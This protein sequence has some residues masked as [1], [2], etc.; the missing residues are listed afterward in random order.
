MFGLFGLGAFAPVEQPE[1]EVLH[2]KPARDR[3]RKAP[4]LVFIHG[5]Y[6]GAWCWDEHFLPWFMLPYCKSRAYS[7]KID[8]EHF[9][10]FL[11]E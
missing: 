4:P 10:S 6:A 2:R 5:A 11:L 7:F 9:F 1:L 8:I 3:K